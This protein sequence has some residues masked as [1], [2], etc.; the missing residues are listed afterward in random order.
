MPGACPLTYVIYASA[1][2][3]GELRYWRSWLGRGQARHS[4][5]GGIETFLNC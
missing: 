4:V 5:V 2:L 3:N 1:G